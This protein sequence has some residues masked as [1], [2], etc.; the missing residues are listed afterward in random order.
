MRE[1]DT[2]VYSFTDKAD[3]LTQL[4]RIMPR[5]NFEMAREAVDHQMVSVETLFLLAKSMIGMNFSVF[6]FPV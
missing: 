3:H 6:C 4:N 5:N 1:K 2:L